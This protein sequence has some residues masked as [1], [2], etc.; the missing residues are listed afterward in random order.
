MPSQKLRPVQKSVSGLYRCSYSFKVILMT[1]IMTIML[2]LK[3]VYRMLLGGG[4]GG[5]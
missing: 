5:G 4:G 3:Q 1:A 2:K